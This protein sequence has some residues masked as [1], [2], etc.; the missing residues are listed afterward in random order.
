MPNTSYEQK[1]ECACPQFFTITS[2]RSWAMTRQRTGLRCW[3]SSLSDS[4]RPKRKTPT[5]PVGVFLLALLQI[6]GGRVGV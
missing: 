5:D 2:S 4:F 6:A 3:S 1:M